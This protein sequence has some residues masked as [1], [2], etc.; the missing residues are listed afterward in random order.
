MLDIQ[1]GSYFPGEGGSIIYMGHNSADTF[2]R[3]N[4]LE[5]GDKIV[6]TTSYGTFEY[7][8]YD[9]KIVHETAI[10]ELP[11]QKEKEILMVFTCYPLKNYGHA[12]E[13]YVVY[14]NLVNTI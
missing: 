10:E 4:E 13:R 12:Y 14:A 7:E 5:V 8:I 3:F 11:I 9:Y 6:I 1:A 2:R